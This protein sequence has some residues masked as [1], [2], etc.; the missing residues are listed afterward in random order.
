[1]V[2]VPKYVKMVFQQTPG[3]CTFSTHF[4]VFITVQKAAISYRNATIIKIWDWLESGEPSCQR[5]RLR[6][7]WYFFSFSLVC[8]LISCNSWLSSLWISFN[9]STSSELISCES[10]VSQWSFIKTFCFKSI[11]FLIS[12][13]GIFLSLTNISS[14]VR[15]Y[16]L[17]LIF[18]IFCGT[19]KS[20]ILYVSSLIFL[21]ICW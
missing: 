14:L 20:P 1:M 3:Q 10:L 21:L 6:V 17:K 11:S 19:I 12:H 9:S 16:S 15:V 4:L 13:K 2:N 5:I 18:S 8:S 7:R